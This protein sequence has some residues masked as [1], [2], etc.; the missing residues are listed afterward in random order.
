M[1]DSQSFTI[2]TLKIVPD[3]SVCHIQAPSLEVAQIL[4]VLEPSDFQFYK[5]IK[6][7][8]S[9]KKLLIKLIT[10]YDIV[11]YFHQLEIKQNNLRIFIAHDGMEIGEISK[12]IFIPDWFRIKYIN[13]DICI[14]SQEW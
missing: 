9:N 8:Q 2:D 1:T 11:T 3:D 4:E 5:Q 14:V 12:S 7:T 10:S 6:L 13:T